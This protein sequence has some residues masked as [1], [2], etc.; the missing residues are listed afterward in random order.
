MKQ[1]YDWCE[2]H[3]LKYTGH[4]VLEENFHSQLTSNGA[5]MPHYEYFHK[6]GMDWLCRVI[7]P[8]LTMLQVASVAHQL[9][10]PQ[11]LSETFA[12]C[13]H[14]VGHD[15][16]KGIYEW[17]MVRGINQLCQHL[18]GYS[19]RGI[20]KR[21]Y[22]PA[23]YYQQ[24]WWDD[25]K[26]FNDAMSRTGMLLADGK[27]KFDTLLLHT[28]T[29]AWICYDNAS[30][31]G[32]N[33]YNRILMQ[34]I[35]KLEAKHVLFHLGDETIMERHAYV[36]GAAIVIGTQRYTQIIV[37]RHIKLFENTERL[38]DEYRKNGGIIT[39]ADDIPANE[40]IDNPHITYTKRV[41][42]DFDMHYFVN[43]STEERASKIN[44]GNLM[45]DPVTGELHPFD[46]YYNF[47]AYDSIIVIDDHSS[48]RPEHVEAPSL[49]T[50]PLDGEWKVMESSLNSITLDHCDYYFD[51]ELIQNNAYVLNVQNRA[52]A[53]ERPVDIRCDFKA[54]FDFIPSD[55]YL[56]CETP[57]IFEIK[58]NGKN[59]VKKD[60]GYFR[61]SAFRMLDISGMVTKGENI[62]TL[63]CR[64]SQPD[65]VYENLR[66]A[67]IFESEL[68]KLS[69][70]MEI[71]AIYLAGNFGVK[72]DGS[73]ETLER[74]A[75]RFTGEFIIS[76][77]PTKLSLINIER[78]GFPFFS[79][80]LTLQKT[81][82][83]DSTNYCINFKKFGVN[84]LKLKINGEEVKTFLWEPYFANLSNYLQKGE[85][86]VELEITNNLRNLLGPHH[87]PEGESYAVGPGSF[88]HEPCVFNGNPP[89]ETNGYC[90]TEITVSER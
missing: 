23:M 66:K 29:S 60:C 63:L 85:N 21:D 72:C 83:L 52:C 12:L 58:I 53:L 7:Y 11:I 32:L 6:P 48:V 51:G 42:D 37:P 35:E 62:I 84:V 86:T 9:N 8:C 74:K 56:V 27:V 30:N 5:C 65:H 47:R 70:G 43:T 2:A 79:G 28:Q 50:L 45:L 40:V 33:E 34:E 82:N 73:F 81:F 18:E 16:L 4:L 89:A 46:G 13:G 55:L 71:E 36:D 1:I 76:N 25:Y 80:K 88:F 59:L 19:L 3:N 77:P 14:N 57:D 26:L 22:P 17:Q 38:L 10:K 44:I 68:N 69:Y 31:E 67:R 15:E 61:D 41:F 75:E 64:F 90:F 39:T 24:P 49:K 87:L 20:R 78:Q 54:N